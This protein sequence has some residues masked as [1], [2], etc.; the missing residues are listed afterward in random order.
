MARRPS[1]ICF[2]VGVHLRHLRL[3]VFE[4]HHVPEIVEEHRIRGSLIG[5][6]FRRV[7]RRAFQTRQ[8]GGDVG[9]LR[10][11]EPQVR[12]VRAGL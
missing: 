12:H 5:R 6:G 10:I 7:A 11:G 1:S 4:R 8:V 9:C 2:A 3:R